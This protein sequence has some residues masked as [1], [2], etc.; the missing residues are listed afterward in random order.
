MPKI[1]AFP[2]FP[3]YG[4]FGNQ[5]FQLSAMIG[6]CAKHPDYRIQLDDMG[7]FK[8]YDIPFMADESDKVDVSKLPVYNEP[9]LN[10]NEIPDPGHS[11][12][13]LGY[14][15]SWKYFE[16][17]KELVK[18]TF[19]KP[20]IRLHI[21]HEIILNSIDNGITWADLPF[22]KSNVSIVHFRGGDY[23]VQDRIDWLCNKEYYVKAFDKLGTDKMFYCMTDDF[24]F[25]RSILSDSNFNKFYIQELIGKAKDPSFNY[26]IDFYWSVVCQ[27]F[28]IAN[29][30]FSWWAAYL[31][32]H[33]DKRVIAPS[34]WY[35]LGNK[36][37]LEDRIPPGW[38]II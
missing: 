16:H 18:K 22:D 3:N 11:F 38:E 15:Q 10:Y 19:Y 31:S 23:K 35:G 28:I 34:N 12:S 24:E 17:C 26:L 6:F 25:M 33:P 37:N 14:F 32:E 13:L 30:S 2:A 9:D 29:S 20:V 7:I 8:G 5:L 1:I 27:Y 4:R 21:E 36:I